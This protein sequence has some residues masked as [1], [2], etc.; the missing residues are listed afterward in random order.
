MTASCPHLL[1]YQ[2]RHPTSNTRT[3]S[4]TGMC[5]FFA[6]FAILALQLCTAK[7]GDL[8]PHLVIQQDTTLVSGVSKI[9]TVTGIPTSLA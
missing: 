5:F 9:K 8:H 3:G 2:P 1:Q 7:V 4:L 6:V